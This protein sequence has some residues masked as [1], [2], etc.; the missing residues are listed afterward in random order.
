MKRK[1]FRPTPG[2]KALTGVH[3]VLLIIKR[4]WY[5]AVKHAGVTT[6]YADP[7]TAPDDRRRDRNGTTGEQGCPRADAHV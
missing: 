3:F 6:E 7:R 2:A 1:G 4:L 5:N